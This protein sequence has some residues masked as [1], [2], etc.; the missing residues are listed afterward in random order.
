[1]GLIDQIRLDV[2]EI[3]SNSNDFAVDIKLTAPTSPATILLT[4]GTIKKHHTV[5][6]ETGVPVRAMGNTINVTCTVSTLNLDDANY[7]Y[8]L[9]TG[10][11][12]MKN[13][14]VQFSDVSG[15]YTYL[16]EE[17]LPNELTGNIVLI[18]VYAKA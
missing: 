10:R 5:Y 18:L 15:D 3:L 4:K 16:V 6:D 9:D 2:R 11:V 12:S 17:W 13:H 14:K 8:R 7:P 1:M